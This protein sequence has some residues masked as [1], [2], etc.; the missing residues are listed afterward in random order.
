VFLSE[1]IPPQ[2]NKK[3]LFDFFYEFPTLPVR[4]VTTDK[5]IHDSTQKG[6]EENRSIQDTQKILESACQENVERHSQ[7]QIKNNKNEEVLNKFFFRKKLSQ[8]EK[9]AKIQ[10]DVITG[11]QLLE[12]LEK[13]QISYDKL[14]CKHRKKLEKIK[15]SEQSFQQLTY[16]TLAKI[17]NTSEKY[18]Y[19]LRHCLKNEWQKIFKEWYCERLSD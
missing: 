14:D 11:S 13:K 12:D 3:D 8:I 18:C 6:L 9:I 15:E 1:Y 10:H 19:K 4:R 16:P 17:L 7:Q 5:K 2:P